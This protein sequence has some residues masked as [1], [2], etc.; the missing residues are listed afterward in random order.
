MPKT[1]DSQANFQGTNNKIPCSFGTF[2]MKTSSAIG[3]IVFLSTKGK[4][5]STCLE[6]FCDFPCTAVEVSHLKTPL[7]EF[8]SLRKK[9][10]I[11]KS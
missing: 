1:Y 9:P 2:K 8:N 6:S 4:Q 3:K 5:T 11:S 10:L 7:N